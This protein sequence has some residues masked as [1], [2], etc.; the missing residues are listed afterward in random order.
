MFVMCLQILTSVIMGSGELN[1]IFLKWE[2]RIFRHFY[3][4]ICVEG[5]Y[6]LADHSFVLFINILDF[7]KSVSGVYNV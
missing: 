4:Y 2:A 5:S 3:G 7:I 1:F 6:I